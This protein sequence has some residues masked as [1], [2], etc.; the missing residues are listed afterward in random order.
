MIPAQRRARILEIIQCEGTV[1]I[2]HLAEA[3]EASPSTVRRD[4]EYLAEG[5]YIERTYGG[6]QATAGPSRSTFE[7]EVDIGRHTREREKAAIGRV[8][9][10]LVGGGSSVFFDSSSTVLEAARALARARVELTAITNDLTIASEL[11]RVPTIRTIVPGGTVRPQSFTL[12]GD[13]GVAFLDDVHV[14]LAFVGAHSLAD[15]VLSDSGIGIVRTKRAA[16]RCSSRRVVLA[17]ASKFAA[18]RSFMTIA[19]WEDVD[20]LV[21]DDGVTDDDARVVADAGVTV[22]VAEGVAS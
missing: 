4:L 20:E 3:L 2:P 16:L 8:A 5:R 14:D 10:A 6:A 11:A 15:G 1:S 13:P 9:A 7:P 22:H 19:S 17:D 21:T 18:S 12:L